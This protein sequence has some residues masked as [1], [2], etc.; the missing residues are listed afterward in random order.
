MLGY[1]G[2]FWILAHLRPRHNV[3]TFVPFSNIP[4]QLHDTEMCDYDS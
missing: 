3:N 1:M 2:M 4:L